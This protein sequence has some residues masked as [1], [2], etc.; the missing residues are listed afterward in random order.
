MRQGHPFR[1]IFIFDHGLGNLPG[2][3][4]NFHRLL[5]DQSRKCT[6]IRRDLIGD[7]PV[8]PFFHFGPA[9]CFN[10]DISE[11]NRL[12]NAA[13]LEELNQLD[14][15]LYDS[16]DLFLFTYV[17]N[18]ELEAILK[19]SSR[20]PVHK[21]P[22]FLILLQFDNGLSLPDSPDL[23]FIVKFDRWLK[24]LV[25]KKQHTEASRTAHLYRAAFKKNSDGDKLRKVVFMAPSGGLDS[26]FSSVLRRKVHPYCMPWLPPKLIYDQDTA[27]RSNN[28]GENSIT[29]GFLGHSCMRKGLQFM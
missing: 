10:P 9:A 29:V 1:R 11:N 26:L 6:E 4:P 28:T 25:R 19:F 8:R 7:L 27:P 2:H 24:K 3:W 22:A 23:P 20:F 16:E 13:F 21:K 15:G 12:R 5:V 14:I 17:M 18:Y